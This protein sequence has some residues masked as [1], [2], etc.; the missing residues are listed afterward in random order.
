MKRIW[1]AGMALALAVG[2]PALAFARHHSV[3]KWDDGGGAGG[4][5]FSAATL[6]GTY[7]FQGSGF[8]DD[9][10]AGE[11]A[12]LGTLT[13][14]G[15]S[16]VAGNLILTHG[17]SS[18][19]SCNDTF[20]AGTYSFTGGSGAPGQFTMQIP[21]S[22]GNINFGLLVPDPEGHS[23]LAI[24]SDNGTLAGVTVCGSASIT[25]MS[26]KGKLKRLDEGFGGDGGDD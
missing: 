16:A 21:F 11:V 3:T 12:V 5:S 17:D 6:N 1:L 22:T 25:S 10:K 24:Q 15:V 7:I 13:F 18:Q 26:L 19:N 8:A 4:G 14:D 9:G 23:A 20:T 2:S